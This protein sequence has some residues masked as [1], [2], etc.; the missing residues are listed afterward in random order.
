MMRLVAA[1]TIRLDGE[2]VAPGEAFEIDEKR[3]KNLVEMGA[4]A[5]AEEVE[6]EE[7]AATEE[8]SVDYESMT[9][10]E[11][12]EICEERGIECAGLKKAEIVERL[13]EA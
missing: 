10:R 3:G 12:G 6:R 8:V 7:E 9:V 1:H 5:A 11:L 4:A 13:K 2:R